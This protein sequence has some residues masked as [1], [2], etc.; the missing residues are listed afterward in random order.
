MV[1]S[2]EDMLDSLEVSGPYAWLGEG[3]GGSVVVPPVL[4]RPK[5]VLIRSL[6]LLVSSVSTSLSGRFCCM[7]MS[8][9]FRSRTISYDG[10]G[11]NDISQSVVPTRT[12]AG[13]LGSPELG[14]VEI[15]TATGEPL[16][17]DTPGAASSVLVLEPLVEPESNKGILDT[18]IYRLIQ[19]HEYNHI[20]KPSCTL[21]PPSA[22]GRPLNSSFYFLYI[23]ILSHASFIHRNAVNVT[24][25]SFSLLPYTFLTTYSFI[26][27]ADSC[28]P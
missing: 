27:A 20:V 15:D 11:G 2:P 21:F 12:A 5:R 26:V 25:L 19:F 28:L 17:L 4:P 8:R 6:M 16:V 10:G 22:A 23:S 13:A 1:K 7:A 24:I 18:C 3:G 14:V 9:L